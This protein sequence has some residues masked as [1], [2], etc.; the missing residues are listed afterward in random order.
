M[1]IVVVGIVLLVIGAVL[2]FVP[3]VPQPDQTVKSNSSLP[4]DLFSVSGFSVTG[5]IPVAVSWTSNGTVTVVAAAGSSEAQY[6]G[7]SGGVSGLV[8]QTGTSGSFSLNQPDGGEVVLGVLSG[9]AFGGSSS[10]ATVAFHVTVAQTTVGSLLLIVGIVILIVG[11]VLKSKSAKMAAP[12]ANQWTPPPSPPASGDM[13]PT[14]PS[15]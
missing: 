10:N 12:A 13:P 9:S 6:T 8:T 3:L 11:I 14:P 1:G 4:F 7:A 5:S 2:L 15:S